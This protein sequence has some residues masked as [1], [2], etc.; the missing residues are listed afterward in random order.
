MLNFRIILSLLGLLLILNG[1]F[2]LLCIPFSLYYRETSWLPL[3]ISSAISMALG[4]GLRIM[5]RNY[6]QKDLRKR[7]GY[8]IVTLGWM[9]M[10]LSGTLPYLLSDTVPTFTDALFETISG[11]TT[12]GATILND[13]EA[14]D[15]GLLFWR[16]LTHWIGGMGIIV[17]TIAILPLLGIGGMQLFMAESPGPTADKL[18][19]RIKETAKRLWYV[20]FFLTLVQTG[21]LMV[22]GMTF[23]DAI[24]HAMS[25]MAT[26]GFSTKNASVDYFASPFVDYVIIIFML[27]AGSNFTLLYYLFK[28]KIK[29]VFADEEFRVYLIMVGIVSL[30]TTAVV[31]LSKFDDMG[32]SFRDSLFQVVSVVTTTGFITADYTSWAPFASILFFLLLFTG[33]SAG[34]TSGGI[35]VVRHIILIKNSVL[36]LKRQIHPSAVIPVRLN[37]KAVSPSISHNVSAFILIYL[38]IFFAGSLMMSLFGYDIMTSTSAVASALGNVGPA[39]GDLGPLDNFSG[40]ADGSKWLLSFLMLLGRLELF[41]V[42]ILFTPHY[43]MKS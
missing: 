43:W 26:G 34:S 24:N 8:L 23:F 25:T 12:T 42:L 10:S 36:E 7:E 5:T 37:H 11:Y 40:I 19:P 32:Q 31:F 38:I 41:T 2:M 29:R 18:H 20:Y 4:A 13:I 28:G 1:G 3:L 39:F 17:L 21:L 27:L 30:M 22:G 35:K 9:A 15:N 14:V 33:A 6:R 16:S